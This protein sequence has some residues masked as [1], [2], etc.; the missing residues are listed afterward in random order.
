MTSAKRVLV[1]PAS[2]MFARR[3]C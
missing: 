3:Q 2:S 1:E